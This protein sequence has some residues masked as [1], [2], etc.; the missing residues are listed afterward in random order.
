M[1]GFLITA[2]LTVVALRCLA[3]MFDMSQRLFVGV[4]IAVV[5]VVYVVF[6]VGSW[7]AL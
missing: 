7:S 5:S 6:L 2:W 3:F 4:S 1:M